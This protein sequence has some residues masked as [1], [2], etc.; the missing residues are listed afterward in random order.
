MVE[1]VIPTH[2]GL[3]MEDYAADDAFLVIPGAMGLEFRL[4]F[5]GLVAATTQLGGWSLI[6]SNYC[7]QLKFPSF[8]EST[9]SLKVCST[10][11]RPSRAASYLVFGALDC[12]IGT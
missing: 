6:L 11:L 7:L 12:S 5:D 10:F 9:S 4:A 3:V 1:P 8:I 2:P